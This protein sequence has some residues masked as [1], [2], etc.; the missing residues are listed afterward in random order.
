M[1]AKRIDDNQPEIVKALRD[2]GCIVEITSSA[3]DG[4]PDLVVSPPNSKLAALMEIKDGSK[5]PSAQKLTPAQIPLHARWEGRHC[6]I[7]NSIDQ[8]IEI[9][10]KL[11]TGGLK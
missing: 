5:P 7:V 11:K 8:A 10:T 6:F 9:I 2:I 1:R 3:G 4:F